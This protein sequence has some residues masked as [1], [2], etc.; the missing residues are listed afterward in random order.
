MSGDLSF[1][2]TILGKNNMSGYWCHW[3]MLF[4]IEWES[5]DHIK[6]EAWTIQLI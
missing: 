4:V 2:V 5:C 1:F 3:C 6:G